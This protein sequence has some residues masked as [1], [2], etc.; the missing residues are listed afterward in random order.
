MSLEM[1]CTVKLQVK[2]HY[3]STTVVMKSE[4]RT[5]KQEGKIPASSHL[6]DMGIDLS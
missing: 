3:K 5:P 1:D 6:I 4:C 2:L